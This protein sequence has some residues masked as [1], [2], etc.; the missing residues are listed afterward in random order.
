MPRKRVENPDEIYQIKV[1][2]L[3]TSPPIWRRL[4]VP[5]TLTLEQLHD[6]LQLAM[7][8][9]DCHMHDFRIGQKRFGKPGPD[10][11]LMGP[12]AIG[13]ERTVRLFS[14][15]GKVG[16]KAVYTYDFGDSWEHAIVVEKVLPPA[17]ERVYPACVEGKRHAPPEDCGGV[18]GF[19]NLLKRSATRSTT[20]TRKRGI[21]WATIL[22]P[23]LFR[24]MRSTGGSH[25]Y[26]SAGARLEVLESP[27]QMVPHPGHAR[28]T[29]GHQVSLFMIGS[30]LLPGVQPNS[31]NRRAA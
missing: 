3:G 26:I 8:W 7:G 16:A 22:I 4:L 12:H 31:T 23:G 6:V 9:E 5:A 20:N 17:A 2:L 11:R 14:V 28:L 13:N 24:P 30:T 19:Y 1:T 18:P 27:F 15:L 29:K 10:D 21:G 25:A